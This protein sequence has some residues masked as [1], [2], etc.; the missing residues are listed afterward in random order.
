MPSRSVNFQTVRLHLF[1]DKNNSGLA[2]ARGETLS[3]D[4][5]L[6]TTNERLIERSCSIGVNRHFL[7]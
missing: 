7:N 4:E 1:V 3:E 2:L 6:I 5:R